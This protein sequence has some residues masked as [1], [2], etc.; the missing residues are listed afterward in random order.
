M[1]E[2]RPNTPDRATPELGGVRIDSVHSLRTLRTNGLRFTVGLPSGTRGI[3]VRV[4]RRSQTRGPAR[5]EVYA[6]DVF[7]PA[8]A[9]LYEVVLRGPALVRALAAGQYVLEVAPR[10]EDGTPGE[11]TP[12]PFI[13]DAR[14][15]EAWA[16]AADWSAA[17]RERLLVAV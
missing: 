17:D 14:A 16:P 5:R 10:A 13:A 6:A 4:L 9:G 3:H 15:E 2:Q 11:A 8:G 12:R 7:T 1:S